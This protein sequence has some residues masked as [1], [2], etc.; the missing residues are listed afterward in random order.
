[1]PFLKKEKIM[2]GLSKDLCSPFSFDLQLFAEDYRTKYRGRRRWSG[3]WGRV[4]WD[5]ELLFEIQKFESKVTAERE[6]VS[7]DNDIDTKVVGLKGEGTI[8]LKRVINRNVRKFLDAWRKGEDPRAQ[9]V[10]L[11]AD[12]DAVGRQEE[13]I[14][15]D[16]VWFNELTLMNFEKNKVV[17]AEYPFGFTPS[18]VRYLSSV[19]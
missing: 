4:W 19:D 12:P 16:N 9:L 8:T 17:E 3:N 15:F 14:S 7:I 1:M 5:G 6:D 10:G 18:D 2:E 11:L 13:R